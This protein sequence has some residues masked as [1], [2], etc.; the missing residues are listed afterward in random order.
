MPKRVLRRTGT[1]RRKA[2]TPDA[3]APPPAADFVPL[4]LRLRSAAGDTFEVRHTR[5]MRRAAMEWSYVLLNRKRWAETPA[6]KEEIADRSRR[7]LNELGVGTAA[8]RSMAGAKV[9]EVE[10]PWQGEASGWETRLLPWEFLLGSAT[11][12][13]RGEQGLTVVRWLKTTDRAA[14]PSAP[15]KV[16]YV[17]SAP[18]ELSD[19][20]T[21]DTERALVRSDLGI[22]TESLTNPDR[23]KLA[24]AITAERPDVVHLAGVTN[25]QVDEL[26]VIESKAPVLDGFG[27]AGADNRPAACDA[28]ALASLLAAGGHRPRLVA[29]NL[30]RSAARTSALAVAAGAHA[31]IGF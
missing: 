14:P 11:K 15:K 20:I 25:H 9:V 6:V 3:A 2:K 4:P 1:T 7:L 5:D 23:N 27:L 22:G 10:I 13:W 30:Y 24:R 16:L 28:E 18:G 21:F 26:G 19:L 12:K 31:A 8:L 29:A 17:E